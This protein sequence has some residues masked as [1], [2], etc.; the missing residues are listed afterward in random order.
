M[1]RSSNTWFMVFWE[2][3]LILGSIPLFRS[4]WTFC[5]R[6]DF[7][8]GNSGLLIS[9]AVGFVVCVVALLALNG[10]GKEQ[11]SADETK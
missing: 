8:N 10:K 2:I 5:D 6:S 9:L 7:L 1:K 3:V 4:V 11:D